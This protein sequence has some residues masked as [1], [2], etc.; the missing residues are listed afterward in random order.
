MNLRDRRALILGAVAVTAAVL[1]LRVLP[2]MVRKGIAGHAE[3]KERVALL[4]RTREELGALPD[5]RDSTAVLTQA[6]LSLAPQVL[7]GST[8]AEAGADLTGR[9]NLAAARAPAKVER[10][11]VLPDTNEAGR[12]GRAR[13]HA[14]IET[15]VRGLVNFLRALE[16][17]EGAL[18][19]EELRVL[20]PDPGS[21]ERVPE[22]LKVEVSVS[23]WYIKP[24]EI[25]NGKRET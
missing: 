20:A 1:L 22:I 13:V 14:V 25:G 16:S 2:W 23:G 12:L 9:I 18:T 5:L 24:R 4:A 3:L 7:S 19:T 10:L 8:P 17:G 11:D 6:L 21:P 15:D